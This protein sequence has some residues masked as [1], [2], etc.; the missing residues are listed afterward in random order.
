MP[1]RG[2]FC[3]WQANHAHQPPSGGFASVARGFSPGRGDDP[4]RTRR[5]DAP[6]RANAGMDKRKSRCGD[7]YCAGINHAP[8]R[9]GVNPRATATKPVRAD[10]P[11]GAFFLS[12][13]VNHAQR[14]G[15]GL[16]AAARHFSRGRVGTGKR[17]NPF[18][19]GK[20]GP[21]SEPGHGGSPALSPNS[22]PASG[23][24]PAHFGLKL[25]R[26]DLDHRLHLSGH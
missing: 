6:P 10:A 2:V 11:A 15:G 7:G 14:L 9:A 24:S 13:Q 4:G 25:K 21:A 16:V 22:S 12:L 19:P 26:A 5:G 18:I 20:V 17:I 23:C 1:L 3:P 8:T